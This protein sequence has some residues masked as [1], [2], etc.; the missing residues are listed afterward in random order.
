[1]KIM[2]WNAARGGM[3]SVV[4]AYVADRFVATQHIRL[5]HSYADGNVLTRQI[6]L[7]RA[8]LAFLSLLLSRPVELVHCHSAMRGS[9]W[10]K[11]LFAQLARLRRIPVL[12]HLHGSEMQTFYARQPRFVQAA[13][14]RQLERATRVLVL[15][16]SWRDFVQGIAPRARLVVVPNYVSVPSPVSRM[17]DGPPTLLFLGLLGPRKGIFDLLEALAVLS[18]AHPDLRLVVGG[19]G[20]VQDAERQAAK[21]G[22]AERVT[23]KGWVG[24][25]EKATLLAQ[26]DIYVLPSYNEGLPMSVLE[27]MSFGLPVITTTVGGI[28]ELITSGRDGILVRPG[29]VNGLAA[30]IGELADDPERRRGLGEAARDRVAQH[31]SRDAVL[32]LLTT[33]Y[34]EV[35]ENAQAGRAGARRRQGG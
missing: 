7:C 31:F 34:A 3:R 17:R 21:L 8:L 12:F 5:V 30:A 19:N 25:D 20:Q 13:I 27:A 26:A 35:I 2:V 32:K 9:F 4:E 10:R 11:S 22:L 18:E 15:S 33:V 16:E 24:P 1:M 14:S 29:D 28:P 6:V 23:F